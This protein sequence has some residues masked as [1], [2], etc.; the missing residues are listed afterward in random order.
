MPHNRYNGN[1]YSRTG[2]HV[3]KRCASVFR[4]GYLSQ[5]SAVTQPDLIVTRQ[6]PYVAEAL[7]CNV[8]GTSIQ[9]DSVT[10]DNRIMKA[11][12]S[13]AEEDCYIIKKYV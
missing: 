7:T 11:P 2:N 3:E 4:D 1:G 10:G 8:A 5:T 9:K 6:K 13:Q 12:H